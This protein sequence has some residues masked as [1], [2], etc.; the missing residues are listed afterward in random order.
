[1]SRFYGIV[2]GNRGEATRGGSAGSGIQGHVRGWDIGIKVHCYVDDN[3]KD[4]CEAWTTGGSHSPSTVERLGIIKDEAGV[5][6]REASPRVKR[7][8]VAKRKLGRG[9]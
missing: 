7:L 5:I 4:V 8:D 3:G 1:M 9:M 2:Q 6:E